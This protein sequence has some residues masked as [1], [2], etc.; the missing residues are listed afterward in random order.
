MN[1]LYQMFQAMSG[2][3]LLQMKAE[4]N[5]QRWTSGTKICKNCKGAGVCGCPFHTTDSTC[6]H[7][8]G[9]GTVSL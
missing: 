8:Q 4:N 7:C 2:I 6:P 1:K 3:A 5:P 9:H